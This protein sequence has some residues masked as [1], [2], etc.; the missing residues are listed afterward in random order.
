MR[1]W[2]FSV[3]VSSLA[4]LALGVGCNSNNYTREGFVLLHRHDYDGAIDTFDNAVNANPNDAPAYYGRAVA[5]SC[6]GQLDDAVADYSAAIQL[7]PR[8][9]DYIERA[10]VY[11]LTGNSV[12]A[13][14]DLDKAISLKS[15]DPILLLR[16]AQVAVR[17]DDASAAKADLDAAAKLEAGPISAIY[18]PELYLNNYAWI[19][20]TAPPDQIRNPPEALRA[21]T[22]AADLTEWKTSFIL[23]T[24]AAA[25]AA[26]GKFDQ[27]IDWE[28]KAIALEPTIACDRS[29]ASREMQIR[30]AR[31]ENGQPYLMPLMPK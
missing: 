27:A 12:R 23:D 6:R 13:M 17:M 29:E 3:I 15:E 22:K 14:A 19:L 5:H 25:Y 26:N 31:C 16:R 2:A 24:V 18:S 8:S 28:R 9:F 1:S 21:A 20:A 7:D 4:A 11:E 30:L 10:G